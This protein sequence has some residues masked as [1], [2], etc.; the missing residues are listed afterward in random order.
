MVKTV[1]LTAGQPPPA[2]ASAAAS[3]PPSVAEQPQPVANNVGLVVNSPPPTVAE[4][5]PPT[6]LLQNSYEAASTYLE[7]APVNNVRSPS[8]AQ[9]HHP[10]GNLKRKRHESDETNNESTSPNFSGPPKNKRKRRSSGQQPSHVKK[11]KLYCIC[12]TRYDPKK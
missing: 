6:S 8:P 1:T 2:L 4:P 9:Q 11:D 10:M 5:L 12:K 3:S 7:A